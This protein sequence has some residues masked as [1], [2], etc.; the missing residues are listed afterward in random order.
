MKRLPLLL[1]A[2]LL[3]LPPAG[4][5]ADGIR[6]PLPPVPIIVPEPPLFL[7]PPQ[8]G[9]R[10]A[11]DTPHDLFIVDSRYYICKDKLW[12]FGPGYNGPWKPISFDRLPPG[13]RKHRLDAIRSERDREHRRYREER[14]YDRK[15]AYR[16]ERHRDHD[17]RH[18]K[19]HQHDKDDRG[20]GKGG[21]D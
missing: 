10:V 3:A 17:D 13:L 21:H 16:P 8:L 1:A 9:F 7:L 19:K 5:R 4:A 15:R 2:L 18:K 12:Y 14:D 20:K 6:I 11:V